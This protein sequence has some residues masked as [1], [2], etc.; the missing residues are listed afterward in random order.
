MQI[1]MWLRLFSNNTL[2][3]K[4]QKTYTLCH[5][6]AVI[7]TVSG[8]LMIYQT[9]FHPTKIMS[10]MLNPQNEH[11]IHY[12]NTEAFEKEYPSTVCDLI[13]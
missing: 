2:I 8:H 4:K 9:C 12:N 6:N 3:T 7:P 11:K 1:S 5:N 13:I 10:V